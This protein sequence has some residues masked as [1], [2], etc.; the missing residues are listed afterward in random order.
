MRKTARICAGIALLSVASFACPNARA[1]EKQ[2][3]VRKGENGVFIINTTSL[4]EDVTGYQSTTPVELHILNKKIVKVVPL[5]NGE[6]PKFF[7]KVTNA[8]IQAWDGLTLKEAAQHQVDAVTGA[9]LSSD[10]LI[11]NVRRGV[12]YAQKNSKKLK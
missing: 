4:A 12:K 2:E 11:E 8:L 6:T 1:Q 5:P 9:T 3:V 7:R 10:A